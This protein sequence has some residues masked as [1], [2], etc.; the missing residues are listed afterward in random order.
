MNL[1]FGNFDELID[2]L[3]DYYY[4]TEKDLVNKKVSDK[5]KLYLTNK[6]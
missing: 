4:N 1:K 2:H 6:F 3:K 5:N